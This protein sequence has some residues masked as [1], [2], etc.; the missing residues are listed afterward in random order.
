MSP[1]VGEN[2]GTAALAEEYYDYLRRTAP[3]KGKLE[4]PDRFAETL[5]AIDRLTTFKKQFSCFS[6]LL[7]VMFRQKTVQQ[8]KIS[9]LEIKSNPKALMSPSRS[10]SN[11]S[12]TAVVPEVM[13]HCKSNAA[14]SSIAM[15]ATSNTMGTDDGVAVP[16][17]LVVPVDPTDF[18]PTTGITRKSGILLGR[19]EM[20][21][22]M[23]L[24]GKEYTVPGK[25]ST[26]YCNGSGF[27]NLSSIA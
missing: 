17:A 15:S 26:L 14:K 25:L 20:E 21:S 1:E 13:K 24:R 8:R 7:A 23:L 3:T 22:N 12:R 5:V 2:C 16:L 19:K 11:L 18:E 4:L 9:L 10:H 6:A 27:V